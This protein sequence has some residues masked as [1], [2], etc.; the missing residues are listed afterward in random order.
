M[1]LEKAVSYLCLL[2][3]QHLTLK[4]PKNKVLLIDLFIRFSKLVRRLIDEVA[5]VCG[6]GD[7]LPL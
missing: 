3:F 5:L 2:Y 4:D 7:A 1:N 6:K